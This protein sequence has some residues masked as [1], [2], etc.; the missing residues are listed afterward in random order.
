MRLGPPAPFQAAPGYHMAK[1]IIKLVTSIGDVVN[2]DPVV[3]DRLKVIF[4]EN[5]RVSLAEKG[6]PRGPLDRPCPR[7]PWLGLINCPDT[8]FPG[9]RGLREALCWSSTENSQPQTPLA[10]HFL[11][12]ASWG[13]LLLAGCAP[14]QPPPK[15]EAPL[16]HLCALKGLCCPSL[17]SHSA[18]SSVWGHSTSGLPGDH[19]TGCCLGAWLPQAQGP[20]QTG[21]F[22]RP[23]KEGPCWPEG[24]QG[25]G[26]RRLCSVRLLL[27]VL[28]PR[29]AVQPTC[30]LPW[31][32]LAHPE[33]ALSPAWPVCESG[34]DVVCGSF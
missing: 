5:Y 31:A 26:F 2:H 14:S 3:G 25:L 13:S 17:R 27:C 16:P 33:S 28:C 30:H 19:Q 7:P 4:L 32:L 11:T 18:G 34:W 15:E 29:S 6:S 22:Q 8:R 21:C 20:L 12:A 10:S 23:W 1:M 24:G 9:Q